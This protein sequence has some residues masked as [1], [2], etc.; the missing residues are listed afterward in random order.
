MTYL[1]P[2]VPDITPAFDSIGTNVALHQGYSYLKAD[3]ITTYRV[4]TS[5]STNGAFVACLTLTK[6]FWMDFAEPIQ[7]S[8]T[9][10][11]NGVDPDGIELIDGQYTVSA[12]P[13]DCAF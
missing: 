10:N 11:D 5:N 3:G 8:A 2:Y 9:L 12:N 7:T 1:H 13:A 6:G 4:R